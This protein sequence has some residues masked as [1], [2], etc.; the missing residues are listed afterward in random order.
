MDMADPALAT[1]APAVPADAK[2]MPRSRPWVAGVRGGVGTSTI[3]RAV[4]GHDG[5]VASGPPPPDRRSVLVTGPSVADTALLLPLLD[6]CVQASDLRP[7]VAIV[8]DGH[9]RWPAATRAR[10]RM[11]RD[12]AD[13]H[14]VPFVPRWR[15]RGTDDRGGRRWAAAITAVAVAAGVDPDQVDLTA[16]VPSRPGDDR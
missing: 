5:G 8:S 1:E 3:A 2:A 9:G 4:G 11:V 12:R 13:V 7:V 14:A 10:A 6:R 16:A 15:W